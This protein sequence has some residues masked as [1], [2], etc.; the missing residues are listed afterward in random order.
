MIETKEYDESFYAFV[1]ART[2]RKGE[3]IRICYGTGKET[4]PELFVKYGFLPAENEQN[5]KS[6]LPNLLEGV[7]WDDS[8]DLDEVAK[9]DKRARQAFAIQ[10]LMK[11]F[12]C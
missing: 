1:A 7:T 10:R 4:S 2:I 3:E 8:E 5:D 11:R 9:D 6:S 12:C